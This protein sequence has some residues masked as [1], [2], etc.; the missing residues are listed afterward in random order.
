[1]K[2]TR[3]LLLIPCIALL[4]A[5]P[6]PSRSISHFGV[7]LV[8]RAVTVQDANGL[9]V[10]GLSAASFAVTQDGIAQRVTQCKFE[11]FAQLAPGG[12]RRSPPM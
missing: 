4:P 5:Q 9:P 11:D 1:M 7:T 2:P 8:T 12:S 10:V 6:A 3:F